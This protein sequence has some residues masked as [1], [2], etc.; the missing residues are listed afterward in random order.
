[1]NQLH[2]E[3]LRCQSGE[4]QKLRSPLT[5]NFYARFVSQT[6]AIEEGWDKSPHS[7]HGSNS[8][9]VLPE[10]WLACNSDSDVVKRKRNAENSLVLNDD[11]YLISP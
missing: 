3:L 4:E 6:L 11:P 1:M 8:L 7:P 9:L 2:A 10:N 5:Y